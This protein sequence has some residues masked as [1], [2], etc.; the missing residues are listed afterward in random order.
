MP[1]PKRHHHRNKRASIISRLNK[2]SVHQSSQGLNLPNDLY[3]TNRSAAS[4]TKRAPSLIVNRNRYLCISI[5]RSVVA[6]EENQKR[7]KS[8]T[9]FYEWLQKKD[10]A[11]KRSNGELE[12]QPMLPPQGA[13]DVHDQLKRTTLQIRS[14]LNKQIAVQLNDL[15]RTVTEW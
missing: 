13:L 15:A 7:S 10:R 12:L 8:H 3:R 4:T 9:N 5:A 1:H 14:E 11:I 2:L 6:E